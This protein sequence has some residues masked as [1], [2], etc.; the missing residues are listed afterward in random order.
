MYI[1]QKIKKCK[2]YHVITLIKA[3]RLLWTYWRIKQSVKLKSMVMSYMIILLESL[4]YWFSN[5]KWGSVCPI[6]SPTGIR[7]VSRH[8]CLVKVTWVN[9]DGNAWLKEFTFSIPRRFISKYGNVEENQIHDINFSAIE[10]SLSI[11]GIFCTCNV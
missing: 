6:K 7:T 11:L 4:S 5:Y 9:W 1:S 8:K 2:I 3:C 10:R